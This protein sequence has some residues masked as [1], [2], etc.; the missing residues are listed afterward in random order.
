MC[1]S[2]VFRVR[3]GTASDLDSFQALHFDASSEMW[4][5]HHFGTS[6]G[7]Q[8]TTHFRYRS[9]AVLPIVHRSPSSDQLSIHFT[10]FLMYPELVHYRGSE[11]QCK[12]CPNR[13]HAIFQHAPMRRAAEPQSKL[14]RNQFGLEGLSSQRLAPLPRDTSMAG[15]RAKRAPGGTSG[16]H[17]PGSRVRSKGFEGKSNWSNKTKSDIVAERLDRQVEATRPLLCDRCSCLRFSFFV[18][19]CTLSLTE[20]R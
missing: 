3:L 14:S 17:K 12:S 6:L 15:K 11:V 19:Q 18:G 20:H 5:P 8:C 16:R 4:N 9:H 10:L 7:L 2:S 13:I 1:T